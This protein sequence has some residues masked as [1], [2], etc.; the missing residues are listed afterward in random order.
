M[1]NFCVFEDSYYK[2]LMPLTETRPACSLLIGTNTIFE[3]IKYYYDYGNI[4]IHCRDYLKKTVAKQYTD[5][6]INNINSGAPCFFINGRLVLDNNLTNVFS[7]IKGK[8]NYLFTFNNQVIACFL[9]GDIL[10][11][12]IELLKTIPTPYEIIEILRKK[13]ICKEIDSANLLTNIWDIIN[14]N[15]SVIENDFKNENQFGIIKGNIK[16]FTIIYNENNV[17]INAN[18]TIED[19]VLINA[20][21]GPVFID[22]DVYIE[23]NTR[24]EGPVYIGSHTKILGGRISNS[25]IG[26]HCK[27]GGEVNNCVFQGYSN[28][29]HDGFLGHSHVGKWVNL[30]ANTTTSNLKNNYSKIKILSNN[31]TFK[32]PQQFLGSFI[33]DHVKT[34]INTS[35]N[36]G[37]I[38]HMG[39]TLTKKDITTK[40]IPAFTWGNPE[41]K[42]KQDIEKFI[43]TTKTIMKRRNI[44][45]TQNEI[46]LYKYLFELYSHEK[47]NA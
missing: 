19:F 41:D 14:L 42:E 5:H 37:T 23:S 34:S 43:K 33:G 11:E 40:E 15:P 31:Q 24:I 44:D 30:G 26:K 27:I 13:C 29:A 21:K 39:S 20:E 6:T 12:M 22:N 45:L 18:S 38:I 4:T 35:I 46:D 32:T 16:P 1:I 8:N 17:Y 47:I 25:S 28:K 36:T 10:N 9:R 2:Q 7:Q 3:K